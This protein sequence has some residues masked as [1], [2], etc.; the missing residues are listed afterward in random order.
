MET[1][2]HRFSHTAPI[3]EGPHD[4]VPSSSLDGLE[5]AEDPPWLREQSIPPS[6]IESRSSSPIPPFE[7]VISRARVQKTAT[8]VNQL[9]P[10]ARDPETSSVGKPR[11]LETSMSL[12][13]IADFLGDICTHPP[14]LTP[15]HSPNSFYTQGLHPFASSRTR[16]AS[17]GT[18]AS[19]RPLSL[20]RL[21]QAPFVSLRTCRT[22]WINL[23]L[24]LCLDLRLAQLLR[25]LR[26]RVLFRISLERILHLM[27]TLQHRNLI[28]CW[29]SALPVF[30]VPSILLRHPL[31]LVLVLATEGLPRK[32]RKQRLLSA[33]NRRLAS[34]LSTTLGTKQ[35]A[36]CLLSAELCWLSPASISRPAFWICPVVR[37]I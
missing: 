27:C 22:Q 7:K 23:P 15:S 3:P 16:R 6:P 5:L 32:S 10:T 28:L 17:R 33:R 36:M 4:L 9:H 20:Q 18:E 1:P 26:S 8:Q 2:I 14:L 19:I 31:A 30:L 21:L 25:S 29:I 37:C 13:R 35:E 24:A 11:R 34:M 12:G